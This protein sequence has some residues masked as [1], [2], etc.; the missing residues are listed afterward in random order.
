M[1]GM[2]TVDLP[3]AMYLVELAL[4]MARKVL[5]PE[6]GFLVK[7][8]QGEGYDQ[9]RQELQS[10]FRRLVTR[11]PQASRPRSKEVYLLAQGY[12]G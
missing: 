10:S 9:Y 1:S 4:E 2:K 11:K 8:F 3:R 7:V 6:G 12:R 5:A